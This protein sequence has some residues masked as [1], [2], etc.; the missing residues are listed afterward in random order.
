MN[1]QASISRVHVNFV[2]NP[3][4]F[5]RGDTSCWLACFMLF[6][7]SDPWPTVTVSSMVLSDSVEPVFCSPTDCSPLGCS[8]HGISQTRILEWVVIYFL[9][10]GILLDQGSNPCLLHWRAGS[11]PLSPSKHANAGERQ[12][13]VT[14]TAS[15]WLW[16]R[17]PLSFVTFSA[18][19][20][21]T[22][23]RVGEDAGHNDWRGR[24]DMSRDCPGPILSLGSLWKCCLASSLMAK[25]GYL[26][27]ANRQPWQHRGS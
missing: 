17:W 7:K 23:L 21:G 16:L 14:L 3:S 19:E 26:W 4:L 13:L 5:P 6:S 24:A 25:R 11:L 9:L 18:V 2:G 22:L 15:G 1:V 8:F 10:Q 27:A 12:T 20:M